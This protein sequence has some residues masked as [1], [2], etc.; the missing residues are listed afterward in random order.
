VADEVIRKLTITATNTGVD[1]NTSSLNKLADASTN[2]A[3]ITDTNATRALS[4]EAAWNKLNASLDPVAKS[5]AAIEKATTT[6]NAALDQGVISQDQY[7]ASLGQLKDKYSDVNA[8]NSDASNSFNLTGVEVASAANHIRQAAEAAYLLSPAFRA[9]VNPAIVAGISATGSALAAMGPTA[10]VVGVAVASRLVPALSLLLRIAGPILLVVDAIKLVEFAW[11]SASDQ[12]DKY[13]TLSVTATKDGVSPEFLQAFGKAW[14]D[15]GGKI[16]D[17]TELV[18]K[19]SQTSESKLGGSDLMKKIDSHIDAG[20]LD[21]GQGVDLFSNANDTESRMRAIVTLMD[22]LVSQNKILAAIDISETA[23][24]HTATENFRQNTNYFKDI[25]E[26]ADEVASKKLVNPQDV[27]DATNL[28]NRYDDAVK[29][30]SEQWIPFQ[31]TITSAGMGMHSIWVTIVED[32][33]SAFT[34]LVNIGKA[35]SDWKMPTWFTSLL[36]AMAAAGITGVAP[37]VSL[38]G[39]A[40]AD[41]FSGA[42]APNQQFGAGSPTDAQRQAGLAKLRAGM[43]NNTDTSN[44]L[45]KQTKAQTDANDAVDRAIN[46]LTR[47]VEQ[48]EADTKA[49]GLGDGA[50][51]QFRAEAAETAAIQANGGKI[52]DQQADAFQDLQEKAGLAADALAKAKVASTISRG[53]QEAFL[54]PADVA[55]ANQLKGIYGDDI[56]AALKSS[57]AEA[58]RMNDILKTINTTA[59]TSVATFANDLLQGIES[60]KSALQSLETAAASL[61]KTL[62]TAG[63][64]SL[65]NTGIS[66]LTGSGGA[67]ASLAAGGTAA[68]AAITAACTAG[69]TALA[70]GGAAAGTAITAGGTVVAV[71]GTV[72]GASVGVGGATA[73]T[74]LA[75]G[76]V[77]AGSALWGPIAALAAVVAGAGLSFLGGGSSSKDAANTTTANNT[78]QINSSAL[79]RQQQDQYDTASAQ[80]SMSADPNSLQNQLAAFDLQ[81]NQ[82]RQAEAQAGNG[83]IVELEQSLAAQ[84]LAIIQKS[85]DAI[86]KTMNDYLNSIKTGSLSTLSAGD[87][88]AYEQNLFNTQLA[89]AK[90]GN[91]DD[92]SALTTTAS[93]LLTLA[94]NFYASGTGYADTYNQVT[95]AIASLAGN[96]SPPVAKDSGATS[97]T[98]DGIATNTY[99]G[100]G[101][102]QTNTI[103]AFAGGGVVQNGIYGVDSVTAKLAGGEHVTKASSV[104]SGT[105]GALSYIN[106]TGQAPGGN[107]SE[108]VRVLTQGF[109]G[110]TQKLSDKLDA[111][112]DRI[113]RVENVTRISVNQRRVPGT[114]H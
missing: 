9:M 4:A 30:L 26:S 100:H 71:D 110:Q 46:T 75:A 73:G 2:L 86:T 67:A 60:G 45:N 78:A 68:A 33:A 14:E 7:N 16:S 11:S 12:I 37:A 104:N 105:I 99:D 13:N 38:V 52:T 44:E 101:N 21:Q 90:G 54:S 114:K 35:I 81:S 51:A 70:T 1:E 109:N 39:G 98:V 43:P 27:I 23:F 83:A 88:V 82:K 65:V 18:N 92:L 3:T 10:E 15:L 24:G 17:A 108:V 87:Q 62:Q 6:L 8:A 40:I 31:A 59:R 95:S 106:K 74:A 22:E 66:S 97:Y 34:G 25:L 41:H 84:R 72:A 49:I 28:K 55:I 112:A 56:P 103:A 94:Q 80:L 113:S 93:A 96:P 48:Q 85:N 63:L 69:G 36:S 102:L 32:I 53:S 29:I 61:G 77:A 50:L 107:N 47:H 58:L 57:Q 79:S 76:G 19:F 111:I 64:N 42:Q 5:Q 89:G 91:S 20:N